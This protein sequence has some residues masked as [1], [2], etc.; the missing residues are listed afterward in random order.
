MLQPF[1]LK[2]GSV[3]FR[4]LLAA[5]VVTGATL[6]GSSAHAAT[7]SFSGSTTNSDG[8]AALSAKATFSTVGTQLQIVLENTANATSMRPSDL[9]AA[10]FFDVTGPSLAM[11]YVSG[12]AESLVNHN[13]TANGGSTNAGSQW[14]Y[15]HDAASLGGG[16]TQHYGVGGAGFGIFGAGV[17]GAD[18]LIVT[19]NFNGGGNLNSNKNPFIKNSITLLLSGL[20]IDFDPL[21]SIGNVRFQWGTS[22]SEPSTSALCLD[23]TTNFQALATP[24]PGSLLLLGSGVVAVSRRFR[25]RRS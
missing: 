1:V 9:L 12:T 7:I 22:L 24:E 19:D 18:W 11:A 15:A 5:L 4:T 3:L 20:P 21:A 10:I 14:A 13:G 2:G 6:A 16:V 17:D 8:N 25:R 23:C